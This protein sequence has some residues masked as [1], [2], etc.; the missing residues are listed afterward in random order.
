MN[1]KYMVIKNYK[2]LTID[3]YS[4]IY[5]LISIP[6]YSIKSK[7]CDMDNLGDQTRF[8]P[9]VL[10]EDLSCNIDSYFYYYVVKADLMI[11]TG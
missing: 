3:E 6:V 4:G 1:N 9:N 2:Y 7:K 8:Q 5:L 11:K 10:Q